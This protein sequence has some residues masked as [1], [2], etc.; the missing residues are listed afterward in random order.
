MEWYFLCG[1]WLDASEDDG[2]IERDLT[3]QDHDGVAS[4]PLVKY[5]V[6]ATTGDRRGAG[7]LVHERALP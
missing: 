3:P 1:R 4:A 5:R 7:S 2:K 6:E